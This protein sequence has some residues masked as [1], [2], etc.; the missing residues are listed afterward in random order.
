MKLLEPG[1][2]PWELEVP[3]TWKLRNV[4]TLEIGNFGS[5]SWVSRLVTHGHR[6]RCLHN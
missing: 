6:W 3:G 2:F 1:N 4:G 5:H